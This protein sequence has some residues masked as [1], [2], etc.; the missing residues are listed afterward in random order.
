MEHICDARVYRVWDM[1]TGNQL[2]TMEGH[3][4]EVKAVAINQD[5]T[6]CASGGLDKSVR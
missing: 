1:D 5:G 6:L 2:A 3:T 4:D